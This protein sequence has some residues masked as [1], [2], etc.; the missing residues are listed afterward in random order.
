M[1]VFLISLSLI[2]SGQAAFQTPQA[3]DAI[4][5][6]HSLGAVFY[7]KRQVFP[8]DGMATLSFAINLPDAPPVP[9]A[10]FNCTRAQQI[11][12][13]QAQEQ[14]SGIWVPG[15]HACRIVA[16]LS[17]ALY[18]HQTSVFETYHKVFKDII[19][20]LPTYPETTDGSPRRPR[21]LWSG[22]FSE[23]FAHSFGLGTYEDV[24]DLYALL[25]NLTDTSQRLAHAVT[26]SVNRVH[27]AL[28]ITESRIRN[29]FH[30]NRYQDRQIE[31]I[32]Y[33]LAEETRTLR[34]SFGYLAQII[35]FERSVQA[36]TDEI[37]AFR[38]SIFDL[39]SGILSPHLITRQALSES[40]SKL[41]QHLIDTKSRFRIVHTHAQYYYKHAKF[42]IIRA[43]TTLY[44]FLRCPLTTVPANFALYTIRLVDLP[45][46]GTPGTH[47]RLNL[48]T[49]AIAIAPNSPYYLTFEHYDDL[50]IEPN[51][52]LRTSPLHWRS[53]S[54]GSCELALFL[55]DT[56]SVQKTCQYHVIQAPMPPAVHR[57]A[58]DMVL[59]N[60][61]PTITVLC[62]DNTTILE[63]N[64]TLFVRK[65][66]CDCALRVDAYYFFQLFDQCQTLNLSTTFL[67][68]VNLRQLLNYFS[69]DILAA[70]RPETILS[71]SLEI[72]IPALA[73]ASNDANSFLA[74]E[75]SLRYKFEDIVNASQA[76]VEHLG[77]L[78]SRFAALSREIGKRQ[79]HFRLENYLDWITCGTAVL[80]IV[81][82]IFSLYMLLRYRALAAI[83]LAPRMAQALPTLPAS[84]KFVPSTPPTVNDVN[85]TSTLSAL[86]YIRLLNT[87][88]T[89]IPLEL[90]LVTLL[91]LYIFVSI[92]LRFRRRRT[93][94]NQGRVLIEF[95]TPTRFIRAHLT[96][97]HYPP[98]QLSFEVTP[99]AVTLIGT[100]RT[101][102]ISNL[103]SLVSAKHSV[104]HIPIHLPNTVTIPWTELCSFAR[105]KRSPVQLAMI[106]TDSDNQ[107]IECISLG[108]THAVAEPIVRFDVN[109]SQLALVRGIDPPLYPCLTTPV[110]A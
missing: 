34:T 75:Q 65:L 29:L 31:E 80:S 5:S 88:E 24:V 8:F 87:V 51:L 72:D 58:F 3:V 110:S 50:P 28:N 43:N 70:L 18:S 6:R 9:R 22:A 15:I 94:N 11:W 2:P 25:H 52:D 10:E 26:I 17:D 13:R 69:A 104:L 12:E 4:V 67:H 7:L 62:P 35:P 101:V 107:I 83:C 14:S 48:H 32:T 55:A 42:E 97:L 90:A 103:T 36:L 61:Y 96:F 20:I 53:Q 86:N 82:L 40:L 100:C 27:V 99:Q 81:S 64:Y 109:T 77:S 54:T 73:I 95:V 68:I 56:E 23:F 33:S 71:H 41:N 66:S 105:I 84:L 93:I 47:M 63:S 44:I 19:D 30:Y 16:E 76:D 45:V 21:W 89:Y 79:L 1:Y 38:Q 37:E 108:S 39:L 85:T 46:H 57:I 59:I 92:I 74:L 91:I 49:V 106:I 98:S 78:E 60:N 102:M